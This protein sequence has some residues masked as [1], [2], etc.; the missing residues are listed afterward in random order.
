MRIRVFLPLGLGCAVLLA[1]CAQPQSTTNRESATSA[2]TSPN[3]S[4]PA[5]SV[6]ASEEKIGVPECDNFLA[7]YES[8]VLSNAPATTH[9]RYKAAIAH[10]RATWKKLAADPTTKA[11]LAQQCEQTIAE[12]RLSSVKEYN[13]NF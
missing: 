3:Q 4:Q 7:T 10:W 6:T 12:A 2:A 13:C 5:Q 1:A 8:C 9:D 11:T